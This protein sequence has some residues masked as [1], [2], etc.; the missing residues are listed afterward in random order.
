MS[1]IIDPPLLIGLALISCYIGNKT[2]EKTSLP[3]DR[4]L[5]IF[6]LCTIWFLSGSLY[7]NMEYMDWFW[8]P[9]YPAVTS[10]RD[11]MINSGI[12]S[13]EAVDTTGL[14][15]IISFCLMAIYPLWVYL[16]AKLYSKIQ[17]GDNSNKEDGEIVQSD[18]LSARDKKELSE[19]LCVN[20]AV[21]IAIIM[22]I[23]LISMV[24]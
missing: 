23:S 4:I 15:D 13:F 2:K 22:F 14:I 24:L 9:M 3:I 21:F 5:L 6:M 16:G 10:G 20:C 19:G 8:L 12:F 17:K 7:L 1:F 11:F 18:K